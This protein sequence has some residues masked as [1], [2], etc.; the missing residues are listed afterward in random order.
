MIF[1]CAVVALAAAAFLFHWRMQKKQEIY[2]LKVDENALAGADD[3][4]VSYRKIEVDGEF[5]RYNTNIMNILYMGVDTQSEDAE[6]DTQNN[7]GQA[8]TILLLSIDR[9]TKECHVIAI[10]RDTMTKI[11]MYDNAGNYLG[12]AT[13]HLSL[14]YAYGDGENKSCQLVAE[15]V[16]QLLCDIPVNRYV[17][18]DI[19][20]IPDFNDLVGG[21][22]VT[23]PNDDLAKYGFEYKKG[24]SL[25]LDSENVE[26]FLRQRDISKDFTN[27]GRMERQKVYIEAYLKKLAECA[28][29]DLEGLIDK[30]DRLDEESVNNLRSTE[31]E[32]ILSMLDEGGL[33]E[34]H[35]HILEGEDENGELHD[36]FYADEEKICDLILDIYYVK[37]S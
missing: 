27:N 9:K 37:V 23:V 3:Q 15:A 1:L 25:K 5:Y 20:S 24:R 6:V 18:S 13:Q 4:E 22:T 19:S 30:I 11:R 17:S 34:D 2:Q 21:V 12:K 26:L 31:L 16:S 7:A 8:D 35:F 28:R 32:Q 10:P 36:E 14:A 29:E 33:G